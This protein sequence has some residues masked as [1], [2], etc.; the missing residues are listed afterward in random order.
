MGLW[1]KVPN[2]LY[3]FGLNAFV[4]KHTFN[5]PLNVVLWVFVNE[6]YQQHDQVIIVVDNWFCIMKTYRQWTSEHKI[7]NKKYKQVW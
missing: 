3:E 7:W 6:I 4:N 1:S 2:V 5:D